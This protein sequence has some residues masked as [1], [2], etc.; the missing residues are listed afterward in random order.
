MVGVIGSM[1][2][3]E[4]IKSIIGLFNQQELTLNQY[5]GQKNRMSSMQITKDPSC[6]ICN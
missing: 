3:N 4:A 6:R 1:Q 5:D 2:A